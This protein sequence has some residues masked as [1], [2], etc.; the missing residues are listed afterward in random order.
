MKI[1][2]SN[3][4]KKE[5]SKID[6]RYKKRIETKLAELGDRSAPPPDIRKMTVPDNHYRLRVGEYRVIFTFTG[7]MQDDCYVL[8]VKRRTSTTYLYEEH[9]PYACATN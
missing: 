5:L 7:Q 3:V 4:A 1:I 9:A 8:S 2:W 6:S